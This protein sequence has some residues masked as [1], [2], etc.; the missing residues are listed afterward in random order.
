MFTASHGVGFPQGDRRQRDTQ[1]ALLCQDWP[2]PVAWGKKPISES[3]YVAAEDLPDSVPS[4][5]RIVFAFACYGAGTPLLDDYGHLRRRKARKL[6]SRPFVARLPQRLL[7][8]PTGRTLAFVGHVE[9][10]WECSFISAH[11]GAQR[12]VFVS[13]L[14]SMLDGWRVGHALEALNSRYAGMAAT[15]TTQMDR[16]A[17]YRT[18]IKPADLA[19][20]WIATN[21]ARNYAILGDPAVRIDRS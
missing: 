3:F 11:A 14:A 4:T 15:L 19:D 21:D 1:G 5:P 8:R 6:A 17:K 16:Y 10:A 9:R 20:L 2:G 18:K 7:S 12:G 13:T